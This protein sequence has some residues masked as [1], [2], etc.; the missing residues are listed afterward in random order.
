VKKKMVNV[1]Q[2]EL[3]EQQ[4]A[5]LGLAIA[6]VRERNKGD[7]SATIE[8]SE[9]SARFRLYHHCSEYAS[10]RYFKDFVTLEVFEEHDNGKTFTVTTSKA[11][12]EAMR[13]TFNVTFPETDG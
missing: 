4:K 3:E 6:Y 8:K 1:R 7:Y 2:R 12:Q 11:I 13:H 10:N 9:F 5:M